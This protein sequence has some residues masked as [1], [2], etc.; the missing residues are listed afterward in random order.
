MDTKKNFI[1]TL[2][3]SLWGVNLYIAVVAFF[4][5]IF[6][7]W[8]LFAAWC[9]KEKC[10]MYPKRLLLGLHVPNKIFITLTSLF[11]QLGILGTVISLLRLKFDSANN[12]LEEFMNA[13]TSTAW[14]IIF[15]II[16]SGLYAVF[17]RFIEVAIEESQKLVAVSENK[18]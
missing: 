12:V 18:N 6:L 5:V 11:P 17:E 2:I 3:Q 10:P 9:V 13:L 14:G 7:A 1:S 16:F 15:F 4:A 8:C